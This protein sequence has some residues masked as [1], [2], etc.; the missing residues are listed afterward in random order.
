MAGRRIDGPYVRPA[1]D[2]SG[3][4]SK[5]KAATW[6]DASEKT[7]DRMRKA[8]ELEWILVRGRVRVEAAS[9]EAYVARQKER[10]NAA[11][12]A[13]KRLPVRALD[14]IRAAKLAA[15]AAAAAREEA[16]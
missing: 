11:P 14:E 13:P 6:L 7:I 16:A 12:P 8:G 4:M 1:M 15:R 3:Y 10:T 2:E 9:L 5:Q